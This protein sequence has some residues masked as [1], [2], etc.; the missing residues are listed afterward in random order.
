MDHD[1][2]IL[3][4][5]DR[6]KVIAK[7][8]EML[9][10]SKSVYFDVFEFEGIIE[11]YIENNELG[12]AM[13]VI[14]IA[15]A[16]HP[17][18]SELE[19]KK[20]KLLMERNL[21][22]EALV[23]INRLLITDKSNA[24]LY[25]L[26]GSCFADAGKLDEA[27]SLFA[28]AVD[29]SIGNEVEETC[30]SCALAFIDNGL[31][32]DAIPYLERAHSLNTTSTMVLYDLAYSYDRIMDFEKSIKYYKLYLDLDP[33]SDNAWYN[34]GI[35]YNK[36]NEF[37]EAISAFDYAIAINDTY[38]SA[39]FNK[40]N[41]L[42]NWEKYTEAIDIYK[43]YLNVE[44][45]N[46]VAMYYIGECYEKLNDYTSALEHYNSVL[47]VDRQFADAWFGI[48]IVYYYQD[49][50]EDAKQFMEKA[51][52]LDNENSEYWL[53]YGN[54][55]RAMDTLPKETL[56]AYK[57]STQVN[58]YDSEPWLY[59]ADATKQ[60]VDTDSA[61][62]I[63]KKAMGFIE[64]DAEI[65]FT[66][67]AYNYEMARL[68]IALKVYLQAAALDHEKAG[69]FFANCTP[70]PEDNEMFLHLTKK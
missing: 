51:I 70:S 12:K 25:I 62:A 50:F 63:L 35:V 58:P 5:E 8:E 46:P 64:E 40:A 69:I 1:E 47:A 9:V 17:N 54:V 3:E 56:N 24:E 48:G 27:K 32:Q 60:Y 7:C 38:A 61:I 33:Y 30:Y 31:Y 4:G 21:S 19:I 20:A 52:E 34:L 2:P 57:R 13:S 14:D 6:D 23:M 67:A 59:Y 26:K 44:K 45:N 65:L 15:L 39:Y 43:E 37:A 10:T 36:A 28:T 41:T 49:K 42:A 53:S 11:Y 68:D 22:Q 55:V 29:L 18:S 16:Q 66:L